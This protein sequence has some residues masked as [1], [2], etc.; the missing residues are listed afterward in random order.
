MFEHK[1]SYCRRVSDS[2]KGWPFYWC[3]ISFPSIQ[4]QMRYFIAFFHM[5]VIYRSER[6]A[7][8]VRAWNLS[9]ESVF[10]LFAGPAGYQLNLYNVVLLILHLF[11]IVLARSLLVTYLRSIRCTVLSNVLKCSQAVSS[12]LRCSPV[13]STSLNSH[14]RR[15][16]TR[17]KFLRASWV[18]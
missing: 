17:R 16:L 14:Q 13:F 2:R 9:S 10:L 1:D 11:S 12:V 7:W 5:R 6:G 4:S 18:R 3:I 8:E 15:L